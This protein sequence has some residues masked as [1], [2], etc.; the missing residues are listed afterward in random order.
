MK[1]YELKTANPYFID[2]LNGRKN[3]EVRFNDRDFKV[4]EF[5]LLREYSFNL[6]PSYSGKEILC[7]IIY[8]LNNPKYVKKGYII[9]GIDIIKTIYKK[10]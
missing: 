3:F 10:L 9:M 5:L 6:T 1:I 8:I 4:G 7:E 2:I